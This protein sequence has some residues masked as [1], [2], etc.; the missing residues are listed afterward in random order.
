MTRKRFQ[1]L[2][3]A[4]GFSRNEAYAYACIAMGLGRPYSEQRRVMSLLITVRGIGLTLR[5]ANR[6]VDQRLRELF[7]GDRHG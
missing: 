1:K 7:D 3:M 6:I 2:L 5:R 4:D